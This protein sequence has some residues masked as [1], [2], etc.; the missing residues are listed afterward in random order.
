MQKGEPLIGFPGSKAAK[1]RGL[2]VFTAESF[3][4]PGNTLTPKSILY[5]ESP[6]KVL[7]YPT[8]KR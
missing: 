8:E 4:R 7:I 1:I 3:H 6:K 5:K 2:S